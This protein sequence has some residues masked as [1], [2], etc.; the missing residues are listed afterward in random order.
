MKRLLD[1]LRRKMAPRGRRSK[2]NVPIILSDVN[3]NA[4][5]IKTKKTEKKYRPTN[6]KKIKLANRSTIHNCVNVNMT[7]QN[8]KLN[9][10]RS[11]YLN[12]SNH[13]VNADGLKCNILSAVHCNENNILFYLLVFSFTNIYN[14]F[15][16]LIKIH[17][18][19][20]KT[21]ETVTKNVPFIVTNM[22]DHANATF[23]TFSNVKIAMKIQE[24]KKLSQYANENTSIQDITLDNIFYIIEYRRWNDSPECI[25]NSSPSAIISTH[26]GTVRR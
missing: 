11:Y 4:D 24:N 22:I 3:K 2:D 15:L 9:E 14:D 1:M 7:L 5:E 18:I 17:I 16:E 25:R 13:F 23:R 12:N 21:E 26:C 20:E 8:G 19:N 6:L 10:V